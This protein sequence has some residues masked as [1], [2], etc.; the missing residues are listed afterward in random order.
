MVARVS[1]IANWTAHIS[2][3]TRQNRFPKTRTQIQKTGNAITLLTDRDV[4]TRSVTFSVDVPDVE[5]SVMIPSTAIR[6]IP[7]TPRI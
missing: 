5:K 2:Q 7:I 6:R 4:F 1:W 3:I